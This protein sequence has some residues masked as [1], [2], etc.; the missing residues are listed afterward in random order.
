MKSSVCVEYQRL[1]GMAR[2]INPNGRG[3]VMSALTHAE[4]C[5]A[6]TRY[7]QKVMKFRSVARFENFLENSW[8][9][10]GAHI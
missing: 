9:E 6:C 3:K 4:D 1:L 2:S 7:V 5:E 10:Q 8:K